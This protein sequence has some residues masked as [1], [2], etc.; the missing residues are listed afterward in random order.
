MVKVNKKILQKKKGKQS[1]DPYVAQAKAIDP[2]AGKNKSMTRGVKAAPGPAK[3]KMHSHAVKAVCGMVNP[4][5]DQAI[6]A[7]YADAAATR[8]LPYTVRGA[9][10][11]TNEACGA[12]SVFFKANPD[13]IY[14]IK[15][16]G[17]T[18]LNQTL[19]ALWTK[20]AGPPTGWDD[21]RITSWGVKGYNVGA[22]NTCSGIVK[23]MTLTEPPLVST[24]VAIADYTFGTIETMP[25][26][27]GTTAM[28]I[29]K[30]MNPS[31]TRRFLPIPSVTSSSGNTG[32]A[33][34]S[35]WQTL[36]VITQG[37]LA[38]ATT[39]YFEVVAHYEFTL[40]SESALVAYARPSPAPSP[41][42]TRAADTLA[43]STPQTFFNKTTEAID[44]FMA[45]AA[46]SA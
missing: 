5:C 22:V 24:V 20:M 27:P 18:E 40:I 21:A 31:Q 46:Q 30:P 9:T 19:P 36:G 38:S 12:V 28:W 11:L 10:Q 14:Y 2:N 39:M 17:T 13:G 37:G 34:A 16:T 25:L 35:G 29:A 6:G 4:F 45:S 43:A 1:K 44:S 41:V 7:R 26:S 15:T 32:D 33:E 8:S 23:V 42:L 3:S